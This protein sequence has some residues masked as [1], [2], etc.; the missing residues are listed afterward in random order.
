M[1]DEDAASGP[2]PAAT[3]RDIA[4]ITAVAAAYFSDQLCR[5]WVPGYLA[6]RGFGPDVQHEWQA[7]YARPGW[8]TLA[9]HLTG[10]GFPGGLVRAAGLAR[11]SRHGTLIDIFRNRPLCQADMR[12][13]PFQ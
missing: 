5:S 11:L 8:D 6:D 7:G 2:S 1:P 9:R 3:S 4:E 13:P 10:L 12:H